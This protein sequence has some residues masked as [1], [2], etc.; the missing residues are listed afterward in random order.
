MVRMVA[1]LIAVALFALSLPLAVQ[2]KTLYWISHGS[3]AELQ[4]EIQAE[5]RRE[6][7]RAANPAGA[8]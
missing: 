7:R 4:A 1:R 6:A 8:A 2:A 3:P 5:V